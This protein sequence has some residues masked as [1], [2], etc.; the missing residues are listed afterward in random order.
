MIAD[1]I[2]AIDDSQ[3]IISDTD[4]GDSK[5]KEMLMAV[6]DKEKD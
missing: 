5:V 3:K 4:F 6:L 1:A 2:K